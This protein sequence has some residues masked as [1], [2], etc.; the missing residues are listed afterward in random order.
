MTTPTPVPVLG[1]PGFA[2]DSVTK[3][4]TLMAHI[5]VAD[6]N[7]TQLYMGNICSVPRIME[8]SAGDPAAIQVNLKKDLEAYFNA[9]YA[10][11]SVTVTLLDQ[12]GTGVNYTV[13]L[14]IRVYDP[15]QDLTTTWSFDSSNN[16]IRNILDL[17]NYGG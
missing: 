9:Y 12:D 11:S 4:S 17:S 7:Q 6:Y 14:A 10:Q 16:V 1:T 5:W 15:G 13:Q 8:K 3:F 2:T